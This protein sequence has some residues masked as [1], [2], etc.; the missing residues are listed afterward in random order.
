MY[1]SKNGKKNIN[2]IGSEI[3]VSCQYSETF[4]IDMRR[5]VLLLSGLL[6][7]NL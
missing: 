7:F 1:Q 6:E 3:N 5:F 4:K 2:L